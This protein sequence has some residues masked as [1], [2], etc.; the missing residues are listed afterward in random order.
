MGVRARGAARLRV[1]RGIVVAAD[2]RQHARHRAAVGHLHE[3]RDAGPLDAVERD[4]IMP[5]LIGIL[6]FILIDLTGPYNR[7][8]WFLT[9][10]AV[11][12]LAS[13]D[14]QSVFSRARQDPTTPSSSDAFVLPA[15]STD[16][17]RR[18]S[19]AR[20][21]ASDC[22]PSSSTIR[23]NWCWAEALRVRGADLPHGDRTAILGPLDV[24]EPLD[25]DEELSSAD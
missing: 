10:A 4:L 5:F 17:N 12:M 22:S 23:R 13:W 3:R 25:D 9:L 14:A 24:I 16:T 19:S 11:Y 8:L 20:W 6:E 15:A 21:L 18:S 2:R 7:G 1:G